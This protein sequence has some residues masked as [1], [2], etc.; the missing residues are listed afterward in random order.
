MRF[1]SVDPLASD[2]GHDDRDRQGGVSRSAE[3]FLLA[4]SMGAL[5]GLHYACDHQEELAGLILSGA[6]ASVDQAPPVRYAARVIAKVA[7]G[8]GI[9]KVDPETISRDP[10]VVRAYEED[11]LN[12]HGSFPAETIVAARADG[13]ELPRAA[14]RPGAAASG[15]AR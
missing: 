8:R 12:F 1:A 13:P 4:H 2:L 14:P 9:F 11:P 7:P 10:E 15:D 6:L 5:V 3:V